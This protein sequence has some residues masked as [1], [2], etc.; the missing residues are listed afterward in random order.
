MDSP[1]GQINRFDIDPR[2]FK[3]NA[4]Y[5]GCLSVWSAGIIGFGIV[6]IIYKFWVLAA[7]AGVLA[8]V[9][10][11]TLK[12][13]YEVQSLLVD[14][15]G[16]LIVNND[17]VESGIR[18]SRGARLELTLE[19]AESGGEVTQESVSTLNL[20]DHELGYRRRHILGLWISES[21]REKLFHLLS[22]FLGD[23]DFRVTA[24]NKLTNANKR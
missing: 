10:P 1:D 20:W 19:Y 11:F 7:F 23:A 22:D 2:D 18:I 15:A 9:I 17:A 24:T 13:R 14:D 8:L 12:S 4:A 5:A 16:L 21:C 3:M 6:C